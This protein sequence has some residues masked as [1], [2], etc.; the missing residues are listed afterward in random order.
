M[1]T[2]E[3]ASE[4][5]AKFL[6]L[7]WKDVPR[8]KERLKKLMDEEQLPEICRIPFFV[9]LEGSYHGYRLW[10]FDF[11]GYPTTKIARLVELQN[12]RATLQTYSRQE[13][14]EV[15]ISRFS[16]E[17]QKFLTSS[18]AKNEVKKNVKMLKNKKNEKD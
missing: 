1:Q 2:L 6:L 14:W 17:N 10:E 7:A 4:S 11:G 3:S 5:L 12:D 13:C 8:A 18:K 9:R 16:P 15:E